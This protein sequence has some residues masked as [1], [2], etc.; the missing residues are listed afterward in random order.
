MLRVAPMVLTVAFTACGAPPAP[1]PSDTAEA[2]APPATTDPVPVDHAAVAG[3]AHDAPH[4][5]AIVELDDHTA[6]LEVVVDPESGQMTLY[7]LDGGAVRAVRIAQ[8]AVHVLSTTG[9]VSTS[10]PL[11][12]VGSPLTGARVGDTSEFRG[13]SD[14]LRGASRVDVRVESVTV[15]GQT[16]DNVRIAWTRGVS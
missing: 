1:E 14:S 10:L 4:G 11:A 9:G 2:T 8:P 15:R 12:A 3:H 7:V 13:M 6:H 5:G 16:Y